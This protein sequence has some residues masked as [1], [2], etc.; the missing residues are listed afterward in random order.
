MILTQ[1]CCESASRRAAQGQAARGATD[2][3]FD[4]LTGIFSSYQYFVLREGE[5]LMRPYSCWCSACFAVAVAGPGVGRL[6]SDYKVSGCAKS[7][8]PLVRNPLYEWRNASCRAKTGAQAS[9]PDKRAREHGTR[10]RRKGL[11]LASGFWLKPLA[12]RRTRCGS[13]R[14]WPSALSAR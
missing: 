6:T 14:P 5:V 1:L 2:V 10:S 8:N 12:M 11:W 3:Q 4:R 7:P 9:N 13:A